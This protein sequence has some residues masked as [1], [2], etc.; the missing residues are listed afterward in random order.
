MEVALVVTTH[1]TVILA[2]PLAVCDLLVLN[3]KISLM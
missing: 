3:N 1:F 2:H